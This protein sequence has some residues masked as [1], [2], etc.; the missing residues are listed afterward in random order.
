MNSTASPFTENTP[1]LEAARWWTRR[2]NF[3]IPV[4]YQKKGPTTDDWQSQRLTEADLPSHFNGAKLNIGVLDGEPSGFTD[5]DIDSSEAMWAWKEFAPET[6]L[7]WGRR[8]NPASHWAFY[9][10]PPLRSESFDDP[11]SKDENARLIEIRGLK[12]DGTAGLQTI[13]P[14]SVHPLGERYE[15]VSA[16]EPANIMAGELVKAVR[17]AAA[18]ALLG[19]RAPGQGARHS[20]F[21]AIAG[22]LAHAKWPLDD[23]CRLARAIYR[24][25]WGH[26]ADLAAASR[27]VE[28]TYQRHSGGGQV[29]GIPKLA[30]CIEPKVLKTALKWLGLSTR[31]STQPQ[32][33]APLEFQPGGAV[34]QQEDPPV[35]AIVE[36]LIYPGFTILVARPKAGKSWLT[37]Q[38]ALSVARGAPL[39][40]WLRAK[41]GRVLYLALEE[42]RQ[43]TTA[44]M[45]KLYRGGE[46]ALENLDNIRFVYETP[47]MAAGG[48]ARL[49]ATLAAW[50]AQLVVID[51]VRAFARSMDRETNVVQRDYLQSNLLRQLADKHRVAI[52]GVDHTRKAPGDVIDTVIGTTGVTAGCDAVCGMVRTPNGD[53]VL[54]SRGREHEELNYA[55]RFSNDP[56]DFGWEIYGSG[57]EAQLSA[58]REEIIELLRHEAPLMPARIAMLLKKNA[59]TVRVLLSRMVVAGLV[60]KQE[61]GYV[62]SHQ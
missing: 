50:P 42:P 39:A 37:L 13:V 17:H 44:R 45:R 61:K 29:T 62:L 15:F 38:M 54:T 59:N 34:Y 27:E 55:M 10:D 48:L 6:N 52:I 20:Y 40:K 21:L 2:G 22:M 53:T 8:S 25:L 41:Q 51:T 26:Q 58:E 60:H 30:E 12:K 47:A 16:G 36:D 5:V 46:L 24:V 57:E 19:R 4:P 11:L 32:Q 1:P 18:A 3:T 7:I 35:E 49:D 56:N 23:A 33:P 28:S 31:T 9:T 43:R 14:P